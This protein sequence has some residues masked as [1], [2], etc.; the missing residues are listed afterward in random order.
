MPVELTKPTPSTAADKAAALTYLKINYNWPKSVQF[1]SGED[2]SNY[3]LSFVT[4]QTNGTIA[5]N[6]IKTFKDMT[7]EHYGTAY[8]DAMIMANMNESERTELV[9]SATS[10]VIGDHIKSKKAFIES[11]MQAIKMEQGSRTAKGTAQLQ[12]QAVAKGA[13]A[14]LLGALGAIGSGMGGFAGLGLSKNAVGAQRVIQDLQNAQLSILKQ[15]VTP[16]TLMCPGCAKT[17]TGPAPQKCPKCGHLV[18]SS[19]A[20]EAKLAQEKQT[21]K[22]KMWPGQFVP[23]DVKAKL[24]PMQPLQISDDEFKDTSNDEQKFIQRVGVMSNL[25]VSIQ[26]KK[27]IGITV[28]RLFCGKCKT[29]RDIEAGVITQ[30]RIEDK[31]LVEFCNTHRHVSIVPQAEGERKFKDV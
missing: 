31:V 9:S 12:Q 7:S 20:G 6:V 21:Q 15:K 17:W 30:R 26:G 8:L 16:P 29:P 23:V 22:M 13:F 28:Y 10:L 11:Q 3:A 2:A 1:G 27:R 14:G 25:N 5:M 19:E 4:N 18:I 24:N